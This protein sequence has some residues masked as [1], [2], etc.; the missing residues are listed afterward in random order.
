[1]MMKSGRPISRRAVLAGASVAALPLV[2]AQAQE[3]PF[4]FGLALPL[5]GPQAL[6][7]SDQI[8][9]SQWAVADINKAGGVA[10]GQPLD[11]LVLDTQADPQ[12]GIQMAN[13]LVNAEKVPVFVTAWSAVAKAVAPIANDSKTVALV[14][15]ANSPNIAKLGDYVY[16]TFPLADVD[17]T[18]LC[19][20]LYAKMGKR[21]AA[22]VFVNDETG[23]AGAEIYR[24]QFVKLGGKIV[25]FE[26][27]DNHATDFTGAILKVRA[28]QPDTIHIQGQVSDTPQIVAQ[29]RQLGLTQTITSYAS[30]YNPRFIQALG[31]AAEGVIVTSLAPDATD[32]PKVAEY[33]ARWKQE[34]GREPN[35][36]PYTQYLYDAPYLVADVFRAM[37][38]NRMPM[39][40]ENF[41]TA[42][43][44]VHSFELPLTGRTD[45][46]ASHEVKKPVYLMQVQKGVWVRIAT[47]A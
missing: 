11:M 21:T 8:Q 2:A 5:S 32:S 38:K 31:A 15:G 19:Q 14:V 28:G 41:R 44:Q 30:I 36:L 20:D 13:R 18:A 35:G 9:A 27:Y 4:R 47:V 42:M 17:L 10:D 33:V 26:T 1:M 3:A 37:H 24:E 34:K 25:A 45:I 29:M 23:I 43:L 39:T 7:G 40:G 16:T 46:L 6:Y 22:V 12:V